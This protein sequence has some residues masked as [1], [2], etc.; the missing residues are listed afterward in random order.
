VSY[1]DHADLLYELAAQTV[2]HFRSYLTEDD[3]GKVLRCYQRQ[4]AR[5]IHTQ[6][7]DHYWE[8]VAGYEVKVSKGYTELKESAYTY[9]VNE[10]PIDYRVSP[11]D[12]SNMSKYVFGNFER[13]LYSVQKFASD[14]ERKLAVILDRGAIKWFKPARGQFQIYYREGA[15]HVEYQPDFVAED[16]TSIYM[17]E[18]KAKNQMDDPTVFAKK[19]AAVAW[20]SRAT[21][22]A[23]SHGG[24]SWSYSLIPH[25]AIAE[26]MTL[27]GLVERYVCRPASAAKK[28]KE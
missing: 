14:P 8:D 11:S 12:K 10:A 7:Q 9:A 6:M 27:L 18:P 26:N 5:L 15:D 20:C 22:H 21:D 24:K 2:R 23:S 25:D 1:D 16:A 19:D 28:G 17:L 4:I 13:C 3:T